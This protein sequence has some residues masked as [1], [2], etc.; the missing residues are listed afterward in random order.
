MR[1]QPTL[2]DRPFTGPA[3]WIGS[4]L[5]ADGSLLTLTG[6]CIEELAALA[7][8][9][10]ENPLPTLA[11]NVEDFELP[12]CRRVM[13]KARAMLDEGPG[14][15]IIDRLPLKTMER[16]QAVKIY[17]LLARLLGRPV[18]QK[19]TGEIIYTVADVTG[20]KP[21]NGI[22]PDITNA[23]QNFHTDN[24]YNLC[25]PDC[26]GLLCLQSAK[27]G[28]ISRVVSLESAHNLLDARYPQLLERLYRPYHFD[29][30][31]EHAPGAAMTI[32]R[33]VFTIEGGRL[34]ARL[35][36]YLMEQGYEL[37]R[38]QLDKE[39]IAAL[40]ALTGVIDDP[41]LYQ[42]F[43]LEPGHMQF[44]DNRR[45]AHKRTRFED[46]GQPERRRALIRLWLRE[47][48]RPFYN[49]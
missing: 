41:M 18:A 31:R 27:S 40:D 24:S 5:A 17:W 2:P 37:A 1:E 20:Q 26:V 38:E 34:K 44:V 23:E 22:R 7:E 6:E 10:R 4:E 16:E 30:Q 3:A 12:A 15:V 29:R 35:S 39:G 14:F 19:W 45:L 11:L 46:W 49:G 47:R 21:G 48:G 28:G 42:E 33:P 25:P 43:Q 36:R 32:Q 9:L 8:V 13:G